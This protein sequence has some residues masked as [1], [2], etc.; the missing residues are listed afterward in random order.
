MKIRAIK[1][2]IAT[3]EGEFGFSYAFTKP[4]TIIRAKN[5]SGKSTLFNSLLYALGMEELVGGRDERILTYAVKE[6]FEF[7]KRRIDFVA[8]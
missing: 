3:G 2:R 7:E 1:L 8:S 5:S 6:Y 4:L